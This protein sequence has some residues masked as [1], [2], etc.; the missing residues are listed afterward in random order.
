MH[1]LALNKISQTF[2]CFCGWHVNGGGMCTT[3]LLVTSHMKCQQGTWCIN[4]RIILMVQWQIF[5][6]EQQHYFWV[7][8]NLRSIDKI[9][10]LDWYIRWILFFLFCICKHMY[11]QCCVQVFFSPLCSDIEMLWLDFAWKLWVWQCYS[12]VITMVYFTNI[13]YKL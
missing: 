12:K 11:K 3:A 10:F 8:E 6:A 1:I 4:N 13:V 9:I 5:L 7:G 2:S